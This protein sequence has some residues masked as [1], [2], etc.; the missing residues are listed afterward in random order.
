L[1]LGLGAATANAE[2]PGAGRLDAR[3]AMELAG[4]AEISA[5]SG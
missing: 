1:R 4:R 5:L 3:R 2:Q